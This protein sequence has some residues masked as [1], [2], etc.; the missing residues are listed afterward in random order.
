MVTG[1][2][3]SGPVVRQNVTEGGVSCGRTA[4]LVV[5]R[6]QGEERVSISLQG[7]I[8]VMGLPPLGTISTASQ[9]C[10]RLVTKPLAYGPLGDIEDPNCNT[11][12]WRKYR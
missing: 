1:T 12:D 10:H 3:T 7:H 4:H 11:M 8:P 9:W 5:A 6:K 2:V